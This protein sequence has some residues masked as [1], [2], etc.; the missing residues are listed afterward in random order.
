MR[1]YEPDTGM[2]YLDGID[3]LDFDIRYLRK[4]FGIVS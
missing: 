3:I 2:I 1:F 4:H